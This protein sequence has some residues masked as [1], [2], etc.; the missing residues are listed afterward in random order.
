MAPERHNI[1][2]RRLVPRAELQRGRDAMTS[3]AATPAAA[4]AGGRPVAA[5]RARRGARRRRRRRPARRWGR[6]RGVRRRGRR[7]RRVG[8]RRRRGRRSMRAAS[9]WYRTSTAAAASASE[10]RARSAARRLGVLNHSARHRRDACSMAWRCRFLAARRNQRG[11]A[12]AERRTRPVLNRRLI[13]TRPRRAAA[14]WRAASQRRRG[15]A[16]VQRLGVARLAGGDGVGQRLAVALLLRRRRVLE[17]QRVRREGAVLGLAHGLGHAPRGEAA[18]R[19]RRRRQRG[20]ARGV[21][22]RAVGALLP[23]EST[24]R[25]RVVRRSAS[26]ASTARRCARNSLTAAVRLDSFSSAIVF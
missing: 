21:R 6:Q 19:R 3:G 23:R 10:S 22:L 20:L 7:R 9:C 25:A 15:S 1:R 14:P 16:L 18:R 11:H 5:A 4:A 2:A 26:S 8:G 12:I 13:S 24:A 17:G